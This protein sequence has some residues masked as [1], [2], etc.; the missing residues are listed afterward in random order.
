MRPRCCFRYLT[1]FGINISEFPYVR[2]ATCHVPHVRRATCDVPRV[3]W[4]RFLSRSGWSPRRAVV[5]FAADPR[6]EPLALVEPHLD[7]DLAVGRAR[8]GK[9]VIDVGPERLQRQLAV[10]VP[11]GPRDLC[12]VQPAGDADLDA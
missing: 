10:E 1:F 2:R 7:A 11:L 4:A 8:F 6:H 3:T 5:L 12:A 9:P